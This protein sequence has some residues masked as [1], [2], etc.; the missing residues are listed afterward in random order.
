MTLITYHI[1]FQL[2]VE[3]NDVRI[4]EAALDRIRDAVYADPR[5]KALITDRETHETREWEST[6]ID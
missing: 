5:C 6:K 1:G 4:I 2:V 3:G